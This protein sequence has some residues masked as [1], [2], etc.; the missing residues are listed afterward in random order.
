MRC[1][2]CNHNI[3]W[4]NN[5]KFCPQCGEPINKEQKKRAARGFLMWWLLFVALLLVIIYYA[6]H[7]P[8][9]EK[10]GIKDNFFGGIIVAFFAT[11]ILNLIYRF[12]RFTIRRPAW[13]VPILV[14]F[15]IGTTALG[16]AF[17][18]SV[19]DRA[20]KACDSADCFIA[21]ANNCEGVEWDAVD[22]SGMKWSYSSSKCKFQKELLA[23]GGNESPEM[24]AA[25]TGKSL[26]CDYPQNKFNVQWIDSLA[27]GLETCQGELKEEIG[28]SLFLLAAGSQDNLIYTHPLLKFSLAYPEA[29][30]AGIPAMPSGFKCL[31]N[32]C[33]ITFKNPSYGNETVNWI[34]VMADADLGDGF[35]DKALQGFQED[36]A[37]GLCAS[38]TI[39]GKT[40]YSAVYDHAKPQKDLTEFYKMMGLDPAKEKSMYTFAAGKSMVLIGFRMPPTG[41]PSDYN[42]YLDINSLTTP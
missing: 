34:W 7:G 5:N 1:K 32:P 36:I 37:K 11:L 14:I 21:A 18:A 8:N 28:K 6:S 19:H 30:E 4:A 38:T 25:L 3:G 16:A 12:V 24:K 41:A 31:K 17:L 15:V 40:V 23:V 42:D 35:T 26:A 39:S 9:A 20:A 27:F 22:K 33:L 13:G 10:Y 29:L 2:K